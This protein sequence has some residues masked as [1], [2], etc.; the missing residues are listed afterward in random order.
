LPRKYALGKRAAQQADTRRR[1][2]AAALGLYQE[3]GVSA[4]TMLDIARRADVA[5]GTVANHFGSAAAL[6]AEVTGEI[7]GELRMPSP[8]LFEGV[9]G[10][11]DRVDLLVRELA[12]FFDRSGPW[13]RASQRDGPGVAFWADAEAR[14]YQQLD[15]L[16]R[17]VLGPLSSDEDAVAVVIT[18]F[19]RWVIGSL[20][21]TGR[22]SEQAV[23]LVSDLLATWLETRTPPGR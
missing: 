4:T 9:V 13:W 1:I 18:V 14:Y 16:V 8:E 10:L 11:R 15:A 7:L 12:A 5:P 22:T 20:Q 2:I 19:G 21:E 3:Q 6:A 17:A 23:S